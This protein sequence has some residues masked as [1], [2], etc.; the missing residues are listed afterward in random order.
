MGTMATRTVGTRIT[1]ADHARLRDIAAALGKTPAA[2]LRE[3][4]ALYVETALPLALLARRGA[5]RAELQALAAAAQPP[6]RG[7]R[8]GGRRAKANPPA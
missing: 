8:T 5:V 2:V 3:A 6:K 7:R 4:L 1:E